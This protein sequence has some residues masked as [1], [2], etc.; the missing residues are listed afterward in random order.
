[1]VG[2]PAQPEEVV[3]LEAGQTVRQVETLASVNLLPDA[4][5]PGVRD[6]EVVDD[7]AHRASTRDV[8]VRRI[9]ARFRAP[10]EPFDAEIVAFT[11]I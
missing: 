4:A 11:V 8:R 2:H 1:V 7:V 3:G 6:S 5:K 9:P 10:K